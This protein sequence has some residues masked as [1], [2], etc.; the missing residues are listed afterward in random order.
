MQQKDIIVV[1]GAAGFI[2]SCLVARLNELGYY[3]LILV[4]DFSVAAKISNLKGKQYLQQIHRDDF[5]A[6]CQQFPNSFQYLFHLGARTD[7]TLQ[8]EKI[9]DELNCKYT[10]Q[11]WDIASSQKIPMV[12]AS[13]AATY[14]DGSYGYDDNLEQ[15]PL[16]H[17]LN[18]YGWSKQN[19]DKWILQQ[20]QQ[21]PFWA[22]LK[23][24]NVYGPNEYH[25]G[26]MASVIMHAFHQIQASSKMR[27]FKSHKEAFGNGDQQRDF[28][29]VKDV[30]AVC[31]WLM[32]HQPKSSIYNL[33][34]G[35]AR[36][37]NDLAKSVFHALSLDVNIEYI[38]T[39]M[40]IRESYQYF[41]EANMKK[42]YETGYS[43]PMKSLEDGVSEYVQQYLLK[44]QYY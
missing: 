6:W 44:N 26:R 17:P 20:K 8:D 11:L 30:V 32:E 25:K 37:F 3:Q 31:I 38:D 4:D 13:S 14:G 15:L 39:P 35:Q 24:F 7:T 33:G 22:G 1:T 21:P 27:L 12:Y 2:G 36:T 9:F 19:V 28:I 23:F 5:I 41:T 43:L 10:Q 34:T 29:Y 18:P 16:L 42:L 40:D